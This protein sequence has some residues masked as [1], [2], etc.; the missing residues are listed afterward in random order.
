MDADGTWLTIADVARRTGVSVEQ[1]RAWESRHGFPRPERLPNGHRRYRAAD[2]AAIGRV[3]RDRDAGLSLEAAVRRAAAPSAGP[4]GSVFAELRRGRPDLPVHR[5]S[6]R[7][8]LAVSRAIEDEAAAAG[9]RPIL[10]AGFQTERRYR[11]AEPRWRELAR[12]SAATLVFADFWASGGAPGTP[13]PYEVPLPPDA[14]LRREWFVACDGDGCTAAL[15]GWELPAAGGRGGRWFEA[16]WTAE[17][18]TV[19]QVTAIAL[20]LAHT[21]APALDLPEPDP[22]PRTLDPQAALRQTTALANRVVSYLDR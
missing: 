20:R 2:L 16:T 12:T 4:T 22:A 8:M 6:R 9:G 10:A 17:P 14:T 13:V 19:V 7:T 3:V 21:Y 5:L 15:A 18:A 1:L 11:Q